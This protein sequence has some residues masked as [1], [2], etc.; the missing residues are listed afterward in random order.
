MP[1]IDKPHCFAVIGKNVPAT[2][3]GHV[4]NLK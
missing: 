1:D 3:N 2:L 4:L